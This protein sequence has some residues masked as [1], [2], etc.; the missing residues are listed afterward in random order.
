MPRGG[1][2]LV[3][4]ALGLLLVGPATASS[5]KGPVRHGAPLLWRVERN[6][7]TSHLFGTVHLP[8]DLDAALGAEGRAA[9]ADAK[10]VF[11]E[12]DHSFETSLEFTRQAIGRAEL[13]RRESLH[14]LLRPRAWSRLVTLT[15]GHVDPA[16]LDRME[17]WFVALTAL[18]L[19]VPQP[20]L[21]GVRPD[22]QTLDAEID[23]RT[24]ARRIPVEALE[25]TLDH[26]QVMSRMERAEGVAM[27]EETLADP[28]ASRDQLAG[29]VGA[30]TAE[31]DRPLLKTFGRL[32]RRKP[33]LAERLLYRRNE[34]W[35][36]RLDL[37]L[38]DGRIFVAA[39][40]FHMFGD[41]GL[42]ALLRARGYRVERV[43][44]DGATAGDAR[45]AA[46]RPPLRASTT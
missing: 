45:H 3:L 9:L 5:P 43:R 38:G 24:R 8:L 6:G 37:W 25:S 26:L 27:I 44:A 40:T 20:H 12:L 7:R 21:P 31:D 34:A 35:C 2:P 16:L 23:A 19:A 4:A 17:P 13:P 18:G 28:E 36:E 15:R 33:K 10:R 46:A 42:V 41:H 11:L 39:G 14:A 32:V 29:L 22:R 30:Y 1:P